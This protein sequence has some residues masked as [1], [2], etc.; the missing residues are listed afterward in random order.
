[1]QARVGTGPYRSSDHV[2]LTS[3]ETGALSSGKTTS[4]HLSQVPRDAGLY[5]RVGPNLAR[6]E[7]QPT[8]GGSAGLTGAS[9]QAEAA[10]RAD[11]EEVVGHR[12]D[13]ALMGGVAPQC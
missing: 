11:G 12:V 10:V 13:D 8:G 3:P 9:P 1:M 7:R 6:A 4:L 5:R 2:A